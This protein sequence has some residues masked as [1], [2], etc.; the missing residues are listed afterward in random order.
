MFGALGYF[1]KHLEREKFGEITVKGLP[2][3]AYRKLAYSEIE[4]IYK[5]YGD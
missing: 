5:T 3:G 2:A 4:K 1:V